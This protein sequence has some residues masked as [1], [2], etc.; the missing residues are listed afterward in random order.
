MKKLKYGN[1]NT[2]FINRL[3]FDTD[4]PGTMPQFF[5]AIKQNHIPFTDIRYVIASHY[6][7]DHI[8]L[9]SE[10]MGMGIKLVIIEHQRKQV[11]FADGIL[12]RQ[13]GDKYSPI[14][15]TQAAVISAEKSRKFLKCIG[16]DGEIIPTYSHSEDGIALILDDGNC[17]VGDLEPRSYIDAYENNLALENDWKRLA[18]YKP[19]VIHFG[20]TNEQTLS[21]RRQQLPVR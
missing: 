2:Y 12:K 7:P 9:V 15:E 10:L 13:Y 4:M 19:E 11:H 21:C 8:G 14:D 20:H 16:I 1:T 5:R 18:A 3:L 6:H 17:F